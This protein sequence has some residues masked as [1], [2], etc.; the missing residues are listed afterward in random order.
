MDIKQFEQ[1]LESLRGSQSPNELLNTVFDLLSKNPSWEEQEV[2][3]MWLMT[4][5]IADSDRVALYWKSQLDNGSKIRQKKVVTFL[6]VLAKRN[7]IA[8][9]VLRNYL[10]TVDSHEDPSWKDL[11]KRFHDIDN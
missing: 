4:Y 10:K 5:S 1:Q 6:A 3:E 7:T 11:K 8:R 2:L 9:D